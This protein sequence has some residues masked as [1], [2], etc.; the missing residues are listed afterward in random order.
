MA[1]AVSVQAEFTRHEA[2]EMLQAL[3][4]P[5]RRHILH[6]SGHPPPIR[7][8]PHP[9]PPSVAHRHSAGLVEGNGCLLRSS[10]PSPA[11]S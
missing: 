10:N 5:E 9:P 6:H 11:K 1:V 8:S 4:L 7:P 3:P 2:V